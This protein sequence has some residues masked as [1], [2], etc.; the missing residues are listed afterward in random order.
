M[1][2]LLVS[3]VSSCDLFVPLFTVLLLLLALLLALLLLGSDCV[4]CAC[5]G[6]I[7]GLGWGVACVC[8][9][10]AGGRLG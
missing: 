8:G 6:F 10:A 5:C 3:M 7:A 9:C 2:S 1:V 4:G